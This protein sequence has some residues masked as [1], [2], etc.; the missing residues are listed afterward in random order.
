[1]TA[2][3]TIQKDPCTRWPRYWVI[4]AG[5]D[6]VLGSV[7]REKTYWTTRCVFEHKNF[8]GYRT[9]DQAAWHLHK[10]YNAQLDAMSRVIYKRKSHLGKTEQEIKVAALPY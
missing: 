2:L 5:T 6:R 10:N 7:E 9:L 4:E 8:G 3:Y 1:M